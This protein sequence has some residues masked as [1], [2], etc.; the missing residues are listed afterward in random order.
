MFDQPLQVLHRRGEQE[1]IFRPTQSTQSQPRHCHVPLCFPEQSLNLFAITGGLIISLAAVEGAGVVTRFF[2]Y[3]A[4]DLALC[5]SGAPR[6]KRTDIAIPF[7]SPVSESATIIGL[8]VGVQFV[9]TRTNVDI[10]FLIVI[11]IST[12]ELIPI[13]RKFDSLRS[14]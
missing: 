11:K 14:R 7:S 2:I 3:I 13:P 4:V 8:A 12:G 10:A 1:F 5:C 6:V 9:S